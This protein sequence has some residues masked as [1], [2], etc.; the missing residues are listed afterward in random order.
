MIGVALLIVVDEVV[1][2]GP[3]GPVYG[4][5][6]RGCSRLGINLSCRAVVIVVWGLVRCLGLCSIT[7]CVCGTGGGRG[8]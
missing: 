3:G 8:G 5:I 2:M 7:C 1:M 4:G 6:Y